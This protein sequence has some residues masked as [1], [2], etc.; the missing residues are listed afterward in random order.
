MKVL[1]VLLLVLLGIGCLFYSGLPEPVAKW[2]QSAPKPKPEEQKKTRNVQNKA[3]VP[4]PL[5]LPPGSFAEKLHRNAPP[6]RLHVADVFFLANRTAKSGIADRDR[7]GLKKVLDEIRPQLEACRSLHDCPIF[8]ITAEELGQPLEYLSEFW[9]V[10][11]WMQI[12]AEYQFRYG[13]RNAAARELE[14]LLKILD[15]FFTAA[16]CVVHCFAAIRYLNNARNCLIRLPFDEAEK[17]RLTALLPSREKYIAAFR[18]SLATDKRSTFKYIYE[19]P[20]GKA[21]GEIAEKVR[22]HDR[23]RLE[24]LSDQYIDAMAKNIEAGKTTDRQFKLP[25]ASDKENALLEPIF[26]EMARSLANRSVTNLQP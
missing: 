19:R 9:R 22:K 21:F 6:N 7:E 11:T 3:A 17:K 13:D 18:K 10:A 8:G 23:K 1:V 5:P 14:D 24:S 15:R 12:S 25:E 2:F 16:P 26:F 20:E 4:Q